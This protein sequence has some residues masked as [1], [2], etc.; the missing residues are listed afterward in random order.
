MLKFSY[1]K[2][3]G[4]RNAKGHAC[5]KQ[6]VNKMRETQRCYV[7]T[8]EKVARMGTI[9]ALA[10]SSLHFRAFIV[11]APS[12]YLALVIL[13]MTIIGAYVQYYIVY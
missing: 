10:I 8:L 2:I 11:V 12:L 9:T 13:T 7:V 4:V 1:R 3:L 5:L 6:R